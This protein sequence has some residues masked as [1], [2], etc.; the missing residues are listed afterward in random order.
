[1]AMTYWNNKKC[2][3]CGYKSATDLPKH[4]CA[5]EGCDLVGCPQCMGTNGVDEDGVMPMCRPCGFKK[6]ERF[7]MTRRG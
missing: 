6:V 5:Q 2:G 3:R 4:T 1:M 7:G